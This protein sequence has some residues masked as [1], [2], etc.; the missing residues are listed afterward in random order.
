MITLWCK[1]FHKK[2]KVMKTLRPQTTKMVYVQDG[3]NMTGTD[4]CVNKCNLFRS[5]LNHLVYK[6]HTKLEREPNKF[7]SHV[8]AVLLLHSFSVIFNFFL[9]LIVSGVGLSLLYCG[10]FW[11]VVPLFLTYSQ[12][13]EAA[14]STEIRQPKCRINHSFPLCIIHVPFIK[15]SSINFP[16]R[17]IR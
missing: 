14:S 9:F 15:T 11:P 5:Y 3:S 8:H 4:L 2:Q 7:N 6:L 16:N 17:N 13:S 12:F 1:V 10:P